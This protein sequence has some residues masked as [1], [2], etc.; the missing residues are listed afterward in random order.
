VL[1]LPEIY[2]LMK[3]I[4]F[5]FFLLPVFGFGQ[6]ACEGFTPEGFLK[7]KVH[8]NGVTLID[9]SVCR[10]C[11][12]E[13]EMQLEFNS[14]NTITWIQSNIGNI[15]YCMCHYNLSVTLDSLNPGIY[16]VNVYD[17]WDETAIPEYMGTISFEIENP[18]TFPASVVIGQYQSPCYDINSTKPVIRKNAELLVFPNPSI[19]MI[20]LVDNITGIKT[21]QITDLNNRCLMAFKTASQENII[22]MS[23]YSRGIYLVE[24]YSE[25][26]AI[27]ERI[28]IQ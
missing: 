20:H 1:Y 2:V 6:T 7:S 14:G 15:A 22:D 28:C 17:Q 16:T 25:T 18:V 19:G 26:G 12:V 21:V 4:L 23:E 13:Y 10:P 11:E 9:D 3:K 8:A 27:R 5:L 24:L